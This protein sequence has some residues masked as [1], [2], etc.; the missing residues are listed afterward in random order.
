MEQKRNF[1]DFAF[2]YTRVLFY[3]VVFCCFLCAVTT[4]TTCSGDW[5][6]YNS[7]PA[8]GGSGSVGDPWL[9]S[10]TNF[11]TSDNLDIQAFANA[12]FID[13][14]WS[15]AGLSV[16]HT[17]QATITG[18]NGNYYETE[19]IFDFTGASENTLQYFEGATSGYS[20][21]RIYYV[22]DADGSSWDYPTPTPTPWPSITFTP[23]PTGTANITPT[24]WTT[25]SP[26]V[27]ATFPTLPILTQNFSNWTD[28]F[29]NSLIPEETLT[30]YKNF[31]DY[32]FSFIFDAFQAFIDI[33]LWIIIALT[34]LVSSV[35]SLFESSMNTAYAYIWPLQSL[36][37]LVF[38]AIPDS[39]IMVGTLFLLL[40]LVWMVL[41]WKK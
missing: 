30:A 6:I 18:C 24:N 26:T 4:A 31:I 33:I 12:G 14:Y 40:A 13:I 35:L 1:N 2:T 32:I 37:H 3:L 41:T 11:Y 10:D 16:T 36:F 29:N 22:Y 20:P 28:D 9:I 39:L 21:D 27:I 15:D 8:G 23:V 38:L 19:K 17:G 7:D 34:N 5:R 25:V